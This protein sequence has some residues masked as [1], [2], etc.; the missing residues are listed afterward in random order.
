MEDRQCTCFGVLN[1]YLGGCIIIIMGIDK[2]AGWGTNQWRAL[3]NHSSSNRTP[4]T[5]EA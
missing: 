4:S 3:N 1:S 2:A 5:D